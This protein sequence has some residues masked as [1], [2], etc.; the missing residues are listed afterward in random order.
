MN[1]A[2]FLVVFQINRMTVFEVDYGAIKSNTNWHFSTSAATFIRSKRD[3]NTC[4]QCQK[5]VLKGKAKSFFE[6]WDAFH[7]KSLTP[8]QYSEMLSDLQ[9]LKNTYNYIEEGEDYPMHHIPFHRIV[10]LSKMD[11]KKV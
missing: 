11:M 7:L 9:E 5:R 6:K 8:E 3:Y 2:R 10:E 1:N 4:G